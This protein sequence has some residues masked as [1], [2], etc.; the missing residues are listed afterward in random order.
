VRSVVPLETQVYLVGGAVR[1]TL[2]SNKI[3]DFDFVVLGNSLKLARIVADQIGGAYFPLD[4]ERE[5][6]RVIFET[7]DGGRIY[8]DFASL[9]APDLNSDLRDR[10]FTI[11]ALALNLDRNQ[12]ILDPLGG[13]K[14]LF[15]KTLKACSSDSFTSDPVRILR[16]IRLAA[17]FDLKIHP[18]TLD[19]LRTAVPFL[20][21]TS[22]ERVRD[23]VVR[24]LGGPRPHASI[25][26][27]EMLNVLPLVLP[28]LSE[29]KGIQQSPPHIQDVWIHTLDTLKYL[30]KLIN[31]L[32]EPHEPGSSLNS[33]EGV[34]DMHLG[35]YRDRICEHL[36]SELV[37]GRSLRALIFLAAL[38]HDIAKP[39]VQSLDDENQ[40]RFFTHDQIGSHIIKE[41]ATTLKFSNLEVD[42]LS[43][44]VR[45]HMRPTLLARSEKG[46]SSRAIYRYFKET[47]EAGI[48][49]CLIS[50]ADLLATY[51][52]AIPQQ[53][54]ERQIAVV[55]KLMDTWWDKNQERI[56]PATILTGTELMAEFNL[57]PGPLIGELLEMVREAQVVGD[58]ETQE[59]AFHL[60]RGKLKSLN[61][62]D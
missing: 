36:R 49:I 3:H 55:H 6:A 46:P 34:Y 61:G 29:L 25:R 60:V 5:T 20:E 41:R 17:Y 53:R 45:N 22:S 44:I 52:S 23:E 50:L 30:E 40:I 56:N 31:I 9:R 27:L 48:D 2:L 14:D 13:I 28:E 16:A 62:R 11:N 7:D 33:T 32:K 21:D 1:D 43:I 59:D 18:D 26:A 4:I 35:K 15:N 54:W 47:R 8:F 12:E 10:D 19:L 39:R 58:V 38:Y 42:R 57:Q 24:I 51:G 37:V